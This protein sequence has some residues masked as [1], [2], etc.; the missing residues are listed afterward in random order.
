MNRRLIVGVLIT[1]LGITSGCEFIQRNSGQ[2]GRPLA[3]VGEQYLYEKDLQALFTDELSKEDSSI[4]VQRYVNN[5]VENQLLIQQA[6]LNLP[7]EKKDFE[8]EMIDYKNSLIIYAYEK[9]L[10]RQ[11]LDTHVTQEEILSYYEEN[12]HNFELKNYVLRASY[13]KIDK[14]APKLQ[15]VKKWLQSGEEE[16]SLKLDDY[17]L[18]YASNYSL[19]Y[20][21]MYYDE[22]I[23]LVPLQVLSVE[24]F[25]KNQKYLEL[26]RDPFVYLLFIREYKLKNSVSPLELEINRIRNI[27]INQRKLNLLSDVRK[28]LLKQ[29]VAK[30]KVQYYP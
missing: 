10:V 17:C 12:Q 23:K 6:E 4:L 9:E 19:E 24:D 30:N 18:Q 27:I 21:W 3:R 22:L 2:E 20:S 15:K 8:K 13:I 1:V 16:D 25:L 7:E 11:K 5:W 14:E 28:G 26:E 29:A